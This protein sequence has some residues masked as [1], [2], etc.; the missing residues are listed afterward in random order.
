MKRRELISR[1]EAAGCI[2]LHNGGRHDLYH[3]SRNGMTQPIP[4]HVEINE[5]LAKRILRS[6]L[7]TE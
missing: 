3:N 2:L 7:V 1:L 5:I 6:L 4:R